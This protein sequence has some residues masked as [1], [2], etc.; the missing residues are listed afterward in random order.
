VVEH[1]LPCAGC[2]YELARLGVAA[3]CPECGLAIGRSIS[4]DHLVASDPAY[5]RRLANGARRAG[6]GATLGWCALAALAVMGLIGG[7]WTTFAALLLTTAATAATGRGWLGLAARDP[8]GIG[9]AEADG[10]LWLVRAWARAC[11]L[12]SGVMALG[13]GVWALGVAEVDVYRVSPLI[14]FAL[15]CPVVL[16]LATPVVA[17][18][19]GVRAASIA[20][21]LLEG[22]LAA[23]A[24]TLARAVYAALAL[25]L[26]AVASRALGLADWLAWPLLALAGAAALG[27]GVVYHTIVRGLGAALGR[28]AQRHGGRGPRAASSRAGNR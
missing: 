27:A 19:M 9:E 12:A 23:S 25:G 1:P 8:E 26:A 28:E 7:F 10:G 14:V 20:N 5:V 4:G 16:A 6:L 2:G 18:A 21:R 3:R 13:L 24:H 22:D 17:G 15:A 11:V